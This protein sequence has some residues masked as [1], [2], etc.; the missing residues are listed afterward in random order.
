MN[1]KEVQ[2]EESVG[3]RAVARNTKNI[4]MAVVLS[5]VSSWLYTQRRAVFAVSLSPLPRLSLQW[6]REGDPLGGDSK[7]RRR[8]GLTSRRWRRG[9]EKRRRGEVQH[10]CTSGNC[11]LYLFIF[12]SPE[13]LCACALPAGGMAVLHYCTYWPCTLDLTQLADGLHFM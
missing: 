13:L 12:L 6:R 7:R 5:G 11:R 4:Y 10:Y 1:G 2:Q 9:G 8:L 3:R